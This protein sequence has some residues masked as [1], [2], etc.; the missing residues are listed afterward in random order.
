MI[1]RPDWH[2]VYQGV[3]HQYDRDNEL[4]LVTR[5]TLRLAK[6]ALR[7]Q[8]AEDYYHNYG[9]AEGEC[10][11]VLNSTNETRETLA[12]MLQT[13]PGGLRRRR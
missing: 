6:S 12:E 9:A 8:N 7:K 5:E 1:E 2:K 4:V 3:A 10:L 11:S 13:P